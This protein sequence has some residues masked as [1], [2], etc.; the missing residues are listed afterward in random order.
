VLK[1]KPNKKTRYEKKI[2]NYR[3]DG[4]RL[5]YGPDGTIYDSC[6]GVSLG[7]NFIVTDSYDFNK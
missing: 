5:M 1:D 2:I 7:N 6:D 3:D 4:F